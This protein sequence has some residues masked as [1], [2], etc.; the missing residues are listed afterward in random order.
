MAHLDTLTWAVSTYCPRQY[1]PEEPAMTH[2]PI[3]DLPTGQELEV[4][5]R[6]VE[7]VLR[8]RRRIVVV[9][10]PDDET[11]GCGSLLL[12]AV[13]EGWDTAVVCA[14]RGEAGEPSPGTDLAGR[15]LG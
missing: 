11:F 8:A 14:T 4:A 5:W 2:T 7:T 13:S 12:H 6:G 9:A 15:S 1:S 3:Q 10:R